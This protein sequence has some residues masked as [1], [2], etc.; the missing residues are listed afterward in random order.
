MVIG[1]LRLMG[2]RIVQRGRGQLIFRRHSLLRKRNGRKVL[3]KQL[4]QLLRGKIMP[5]FHCN[6]CHHEWEGLESWTECKWCGSEGYIIQ[7]K[8]HFE[9]WL[10]DGMPLYG[11]DEE[12]KK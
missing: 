2:G 9:K 6:K 12:E 7:E 4:M 11:F 3:E 8:T 1:L 5:L 10:D